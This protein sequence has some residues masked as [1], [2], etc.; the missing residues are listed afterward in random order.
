MQTVFVSESV[1]PPPIPTSVAD[2]S[3]PAPAQQPAP[4]SQWI[5]VN[6]II[7]DLSIKQWM[8]RMFKFGLALAV[9][10]IALLI[11]LLVI[12]AIEKYVGLTPGRPF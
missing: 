6:L 9:V 10:Y 12:A 3:R 8:Q 7:P 2:H 1:K 11:P 5:N 4:P